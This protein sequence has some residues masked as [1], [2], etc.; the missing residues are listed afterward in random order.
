MGLESL[1]ASFVV[2]AAALPALAPRD[3]DIQRPPP[4]PYAPAATDEKF[5]DREFY[6]TCRITATGRL[7]D[8]RT[9]GAPN[10]GP[11]RWALAYIATWKVAAKTHA[12]ARSGN[13]LIR[14]PVRLRDG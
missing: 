7:T 14:I 13:R 9:H 5:G 3:I 1:A 11:E 12:G 8:C 10:R 2:L 6:V 4:T